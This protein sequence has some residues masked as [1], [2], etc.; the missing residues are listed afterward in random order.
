MPA[1]EDPTPQVHPTA[2]VDDGAE[3]GAAT[4]IWHSSHVMPGAVVGRDCIL[5]QNVYVG[6]DVRV[7]DGVKI[8]N[9][10]SVYEGVTL[11][12]GVFCGPSVVFTNVVD[13]RAHID[14][15]H[16]FRPTLVRRGATLGANA[17]ILCGVT[18]GEWA[19]VGA[20]AVV[21]HDVPDHALVIGVPARLAGWVCECGR[22]LDAEGDVGR[23]PD[24]GSS[25]DLPTRP[26]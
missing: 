6:R 12:D 17:T 14:R 20:G 19:F 10:V 4:R 2:T 24:C 9:N 16:E 8:Q 23:C 26:S 1:G 11:E 22:R 15:K 3:I 7:G 25:F 21:T 18:I 5:G 13:P